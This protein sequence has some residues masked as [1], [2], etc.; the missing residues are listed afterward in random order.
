MGEAGPA[1]PGIVPTAMLGGRL[2][3]YQSAGGHRAGT[4]AV[5]LAAAAE[6]DAGARIVD[7]GS[8]VGTVGLAL[9]LREPSASVLLVEVVPESAALARRNVALNGLAGRAAV[10]ELDLFD[11]DA[12]AAWA[13]TASLVVSN[14]PFF[15]AGTTRPSPDT[16]KRSAHSL[17]GAGAPV[18]H[19]DWLRAALS[20][21]APQGRLVMIH[22]PDALAAL[23]AASD[24]RLG[25]IV[26][27]PVYAR[28]EG[29]AIRILF[30]GVAGSRAPLALAEPLVLHDANGV[31]RPD[32][33]AMHRGAGTLPLLPKRKK[34][35][36]RAGS[37]MR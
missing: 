11:R 29:P 25:N 23:L 7:V 34:P 31:F 28:A 1:A 10:A 22:R 32:V 21:L 5:L 27:R 18:S 33:E 6:P 19:G 20:F 4:D 15:E 37:P 13:G 16:A 26:V 17:A 3:L 12:R 30:G 24:G 14:P 2:Q 36:P 8:G 9:A 35:A